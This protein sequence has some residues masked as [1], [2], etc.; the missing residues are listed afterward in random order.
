MT[1]IFTEA[2]LV[3]FFLRLLGNNLAGILVAGIFSQLSALVHKVSNLLIRYGY[4]IVRIYEN[5]F[6]FALKQFKNIDLTPERA[7]LYVILVYAALGVLA[8]ISGY[9]I[10]KKATTGN[11]RKE[12]Q[13]NKLVLDTSWDFLAPGQRFHMFL[14]FLLPYSISYYW[15]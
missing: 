1:G 2:L 5:I 8:A 10:G 15:H 13:H 3:D 14:L 6:E 12:I 7:V 4:D 9:R 11:P